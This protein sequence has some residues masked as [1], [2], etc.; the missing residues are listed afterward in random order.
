V[1]EDACVSE[2]HMYS[3][4]ML[5]RDNDIAY[6]D[7]RVSEHHAKSAIVEDASGVRYSASMLPQ[8][9]GSENVSSHYEI[10]DDT[11]PGTHANQTLQSCI[12]YDPLEIDDEVFGIIEDERDHQDE[13]EYAIPRDVC[14]SG[15]C[16]SR[17]F[18]KVTYYKKLGNALEEGCLE[19]EDA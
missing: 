6:E 9:N 13:D 11:P 7:A 1:C 17:D 3:A 10:V 18:Q 4:S 19:D 2:H 12:V 8:D 14:V 15:V 16:A 5:P